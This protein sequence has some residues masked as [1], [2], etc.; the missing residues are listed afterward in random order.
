[1]SKTRRNDILWYDLSE[2]LRYRGTNPTRGVRVCLSALLQSGRTDLHEIVGGRVQN[3]PFTDPGP[4][5]AQSTV[6]RTGDCA[7][8]TRA[9]TVMHV[10]TPVR[11]TH[12]CTTCPYD[13]GVLTFVMF[14]T[15][16][17]QKKR[18]RI[19]A[20]DPRRPETTWGRAPMR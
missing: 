2:P 10:R 1:M 3:M 17:V 5:V 6:H 18:K 15:T 12:R 7:W 16:M 13:V 4:P 9:A 14:V 19:C 8:I 20:T 11:S